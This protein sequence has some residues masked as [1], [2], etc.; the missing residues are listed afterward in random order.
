MK[1]KILVALIGILVTVGVLVLSFKTKIDWRKMQAVEVYT[2]STEW[3]AFEKMKDVDLDSKA[4]YSLNLE[5]AKELFDKAKTEV[6][7]LTVWR[8]YR[9][10]VVYFE[11]G[12]PLRLKVSNDGAF[13]IVLNF[14]RKYE[15]RKADLEAWNRLWRN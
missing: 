10:A 13:F 6:Q 5:Q 2:D 9:Y 15:I 12:K 14:G 3:K 1:T 4:H 7:F 11:E 8:G